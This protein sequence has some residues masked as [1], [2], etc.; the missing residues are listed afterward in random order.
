M[1]LE[2]LLQILTFDPAGSSQSSTPL[3]KYRSRWL[4]TQRNVPSDVPSDGTLAYT[5]NDL[6]QRGTWASQVALVVR[7]PPAKA[8]NNET[9]V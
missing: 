4:L 2:K 3:C 9:G 7:N 1:F 5:T 6:K 8:G